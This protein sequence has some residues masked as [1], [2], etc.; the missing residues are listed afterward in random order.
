MLNTN[1]FSHFHNVC[2]SFLSKKRQSQDGVVEGYTYSLLRPGSIF[3][4]S[5][6]SNGVAFVAGA[7]V[8]N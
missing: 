2:N 8:R 3:N 1:T 6:G 7:N 4:Q 5:L